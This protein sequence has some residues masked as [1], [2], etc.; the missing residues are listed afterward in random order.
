MTYE[1]SVTY[2]SGLVAF[3]VRADREPFRRLLARLG[4]PEAS[5]RC[6]HVA[7]T[8]GK[9]STTT[10]IASVLSAAGYRVGS[11]LSPFVF[12]LRERIQ[13]NAALIPKEDFA[14]LVTVVRP[15]IEAITANGIGQIPNLN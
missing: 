9:G 11:Y 6:L 14:R 8:N 2:L 5:L 7:G 1:E 13:I 10:F 12:D 3:A 4:N 15:H